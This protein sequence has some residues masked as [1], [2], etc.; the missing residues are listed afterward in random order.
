MPA[1][2]SCAVGGAP[3]EISSSS[4]APFATEKLL[5]AIMS[6][7]DGWASVGP[8][9]SHTKQP[10]FTLQV[11]VTPPVLSA[12][13]PEGREVW[14]SAGTSLGREFIGVSDVA[15]S[16]PQILPLASSSQPK[17]IAF[18]VLEALRS[19]PILPRVGGEEGGQARKAGR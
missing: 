15:V 14:V 2:S 3:L 17:H 12:G 19:P 6:V 10:I 9:V 4:G 5:F 13:V 18:L 7:T 16:G 8:G 1:N 11:R